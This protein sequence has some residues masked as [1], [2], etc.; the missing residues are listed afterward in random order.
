MK[1]PGQPARNRFSTNTIRSEGFTP[2]TGDPPWLVTRSSTPREK[3]NGSF[4]A[5]RK[6]AR[7]PPSKTY[8]FQHKPYQHLTCLLF[9][10]H[11]APCGPAFGNQPPEQKM[12]RKPLRRLSLS[13]SLSLRNRSLDLRRTHRCQTRVS[14]SPAKP[15]EERIPGDQSPRHAREE[16]HD[17][18]GV[19]RSR[20]C[21]DGRR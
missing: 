11:T 12:Y 6:A 15:G 10:C 17:H 20:T 16:E 21:S 13:L 18:Q 3:K 5:K 9:E 14:G 4:P 1:Q 2:K 7:S 19:P 8:N